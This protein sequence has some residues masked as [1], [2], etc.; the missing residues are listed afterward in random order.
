MSY[1]LCASVTKLSHGL[2]IWVQQ[3][4]L[5]AAL[6]ILVVIAVLYFKGVFGGIPAVWTFFTHRYD[7]M[8]SGFEKARQNVFSFSV[9]QVGVSCRHLLNHFPI[10]LRSILSPQSRV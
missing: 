8:E 7:F 6:V 9:L 2:G 5:H 3:F 4:Q 1:S 10:L